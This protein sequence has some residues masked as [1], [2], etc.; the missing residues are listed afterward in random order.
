MRGTET[1]D[2]QDSVWSCG[3]VVGLIK[4]IPTV[5]HLVDDIVQE[6]IFTIESR[7]LRMIVPAGPARL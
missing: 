2:T 1:G 5:Q 7:L 3:Q 4:D 6:A